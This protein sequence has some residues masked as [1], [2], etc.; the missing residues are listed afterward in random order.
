MANPN[1]IDVSEIKG[2]TSLQNISTS[3]TEIVAN[4]S[5]SNK[6][7]KINSL[8]VSNISGNTAGEVT[9]DFFRDSQSFKFAS[10]ISVPA[11]ATLV[12]ISK[13]T[14]VYL[15]EGDS[16]RCEASANNQLQAVCSYEEI[17]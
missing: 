8:V 5:A 6:I 3:A 2:K 16:I 14:G 11:N 1:I 7:I 12:V 9:V 4:G 13:E 17:S 15:E 10:T